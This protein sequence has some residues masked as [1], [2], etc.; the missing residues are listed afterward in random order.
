MRERK[1]SRTAFRGLSASAALSA[2]AKEQRNLI[3]RPTATTVKLQ[4]GEEI[5]RF[6]SKGVAEVELANG[7]HAMA[8]SVG[9]PLAV[10]A[11]RGR[12]APVDLGLR[13]KLDGWAPARPAVPVSLPKAGA[14]DATVGSSLALNLPN[15]RGTGEL[16]DDAKAFYSGQLK[17]ADIL[18]EPKNSGLELSW[19]LRSPEAPSNLPVDL[20]LTA[21]RQLGV[22]VLNDGSVELRDGAKLAGTVSPLVSWD[23]QGRA[24]EAR[25][26]VDRGRLSIAVDHATADLAYPIVIDPLV[27]TPEGATAMTDDN[28]GGRAGWYFDSQTPGSFWRSYPELGDAKLSLA[29][30]NGNQTG[31]A[32]WVFDPIRQSSVFRVDF[33]NFTRDLGRATTKLGIVHKNPQIGWQDTNW[34]NY[35][36]ASSPNNPGVNIAGPFEE[37]N[38]GIS[39]PL[40]I[41]ACASPSCSSEGSPDNLAI[42]Q[43]FNVSGDNRPT[44]VGGHMDGAIVWH[45][46]ST[47]PTFNS[48]SFAPPAQNGWTRAG[49]LTATASLTD[50]GIGMCD[51][52][53]LVDQNIVNAEQTH[54]LTV[55]DLALAASEDVGFGWVGG[56]HGETT[57][58]PADSNASVT[59]N[60]GAP[61]RPS[62]QEGIRS[63]SFIASDML[64]NHAAYPPVTVKV[65]RTPPQVDPG[66]KIGLLAVPRTGADLPAAKD[67]R[68][69]TG[70]AD[71]SVLITDGAITGVTPGNTRSG[72]ATVSSGIYRLD[73]TG[74]RTSGS[75][76]SPVA[77]TAPNTD[78]AQYYGNLTAGT[79]PLASQVT[80]VPGLYELEV[81]A[82]DRAGNSTTKR[83]VFGVSNASID[84]VIDGQGTARWVP[85]Q[86]SRSGWNGSL[87]I[88][89]CDTVHTS[90]TAVQNGALQLEKDNTNADPSSIAM[91]NGLTDRYVLDLQSVLASAANPAQTNF[92][93]DRLRIRARFNGGTSYSDY[94]EDVKIRLDRGGRSTDDANTD[95][96]FGDVDLLTGNVAISE[97]DVGVDSYLSGLSIE[98]TYHSRYGDQGGPL[99]PGWRLGVPTEGQPEFTSIQ[100]LE[101]SELPDDQRTLAVEVSKADGEKFAFERQDSDSA[102]KPEAGF[103]DYRLARIASSDPR[104]AAR[105]EIRDT[106]TGASAVFSDRLPAS[107]GAAADANKAGT[108]VV[109]PGAWALSRT[110]PAV[111]G[112]APKYVYGS[113]VAGTQ[114]TRV[115]APTDGLDCTGTL[116]RGCQVL[117]FTYGT[118]TG[119]A[120]R[121]TSISMTTTDPATG[122]LTAPLPLVT[123]GYSP[124]VGARLTS[125][126]DNRTGVVDSYA[127][128]SDGLVSQVTPPG[129]RPYNLTYDTTMASQDAGAKGRLSSVQRDSLVASTPVATWTMKYD[130]PRT[131]SSAP[132]DMGFSSVD[133]W[134]QKVTPF[135]A[136]G[137]VAPGQTAGSSQQELQKL[138]LWY[139]DALGRTINEVEPGPADGSGNP[140]AAAI[141]AIDLN[142][143]GNVTRSITAANLAA[144][145]ADPTDKKAAA[146]RL[147]TQTTYSDN[148][149]QRVLDVKGPE[150][151]V[152]LPGTTVSVK[153]R[154]HQWSSNSEFDEGVPAP[155]VAGQPELGTTND[156][157]Y[158]FN[159]PTTVHSATYV[160]QGAG[161]GTDQDAHI[162]KREYDWKSRQAKK[163]VEDATGLART[164]TFVYNDDGAETER[165]QPSSAASGGQNT[166]PTT[167]LTSYY[168][169]NATDPDC[170]GKP[171][172]VGLPCKVGPAAQPTASGLPALPV[173]KYTYDLWRRVAKVTETVAGTQ[174]R[175]SERF[176]NSASDLVTRERVTGTV[177]RAVYDTSHEYD[178][179]GRETATRTLNADNSVVRSI[180]RS[181][182]ALSRVTTYTDASGNSRTTTYDLSG[183]PATVTDNKTGTTTTSATRTFTYDPL[184]GDAKTVADSAIGSTTATYDI[185]GRPTLIA[186]PGEIT[187][188]RTYDTLGQPAI[189]VYMRS[190]SGLLYS[191]SVS[192]GPGG[193]LMSDASSLGNRQYSYDGVGRLTNVNDTPAGAVCTARSYSYDIN[194]N[195]L[196]KRTAS[197][198]NV[199]DACP[200]SGGSTVTQTYDG[201]AD[202]MTGVTGANG[203][204]TV[205]YDALGRV[206]TVPAEANGGGASSQTFEYFVND[207]A[208]KSVGSGYTVTNALDPLLRTY[209]RVSI[210]TSGPIQTD[211]YAFG[212]DA[213]VP[214]FTS[215]GSTWT[216]YLEDP[217]GGMALQT[218]NA[219]ATT[220]QIANIRGDVV[221]EMPID[222]TSLTTKFAVDEY[223]VPTGSQLDGR[224]YGFLGA[225]QREATNA[226][227]VVAMGVR[228]YLPQIGRFGQPDPV[229]GGSANPYD[230]VDGDPVNKLDLDG[231]AMR[232]SNGRNY[233]G[234]DGP[235][236]RRPK[237]VPAPPRPMPLPKP[238]PVPPR[239]APPVRKP[240]PPKFKSKGGSNGITERTYLG[241]IPGIIRRGKQ[242]TVKAATRCAVTT[243][244]GGV[245]GAAGGVLA[246]NA[247]AGASAAAQ[248]AAARAAAVAAVAAK[249]NVYALAIGCAVAGLGV[250]P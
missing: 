90:W 153:G 20:G 172:W 50:T 51:D 156:P 46:E 189:Q 41:K 146:D 22:Q 83:Y 125:V 228:L 76:V 15:D 123:Y 188:S 27:W 86:V 212:S 117:D 47:P 150:A 11:G 58:M 233:P 149:Y 81:N 18:L 211:T 64:G 79:G 62:I 180:T 37:G 164:R 96:G 112:K 84:T 70:A 192:R 250:E 14:Q 73:A 110:V 93:N 176:Y 61:T 157:N 127:Y 105:F 142:K 80:S 221:G 197:G 194:S 98:R 74:N 225:A 136:T 223:G 66:G 147:S 29:M 3:E 145:L 75:L 193:A 55:R 31:I 54:P 108:G 165:R 103:E 57:Y 222:G 243:V 236:K 82:T 63:L 227:G 154:A 128:N 59:W 235:S 135:R 133:R 60:E 219:G 132:W 166:A 44:P 138:K 88:E 242:E 234:S 53:N 169:S 141:S 121:L 52:G 198:A 184:T 5:V 226:G 17:D 245:I 106:S 241:S 42:F 208:Y 72:V 191:N 168:R 174:V 38:T 207:L 13:V 100:D 26:V 4:R 200:T 162:A 186:Y 10:P 77:G 187:R 182:D 45:R 160:T 216:R 148:A 126:T 109:D 199:G 95:L 204:G 7:R 39:D 49:Q 101:D 124:D 21:G 214:M 140:T 65:D 68:T 155:S 34:T 78:N 71:L 143:Y 181:Y 67:I 183:R 115:I 240:A 213:D 206:L 6:H 177:G 137:L 107:S 33:M 23:A 220:L 237:P 210:P 118:T 215:R 248:A 35:R 203:S 170:Q 171:E 134:G 173:R 16:V 87:S 56:C 159:L 36:F 178:A 2:V 19:V 116:V 30:P 144:A 202:R 249:G 111:S 119:G 152:R 9:G 24:V 113:T 244:T 209:L 48:L 185:A 122:Q 205:T 217:V 104:K 114:L 89:W 158:P 25:Y 232:M 91:T 1:R 139:L 238:R 94:S 92:P 32:Q 218:T 247:G 43:M 230:Y 196:S 190:G 229:L 99:G 195:R 175:E 69:F 8:E 130:V 129:E 151:P 201:Q 179:Y 97:S 231:R 102:Y 163:I 161:A 120:K 85:I 12:F 167:T 224:K 131:G 40:S 28:G 246:S 239:P